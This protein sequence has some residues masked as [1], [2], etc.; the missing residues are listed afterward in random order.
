M[1]TTEAINR[2]NQG[3]KVHDNKVCFALCL[4]FL[5]FF[6]FFF[7][8]NLNS[9]THQLLNINWNVF[10]TANVAL[11]FLVTLHAP[12]PPQKTPKIVIQEVYTDILIIFVCFKDI[13]LKSTF[14]SSLEYSIVSHCR[15]PNSR[16]RK[17]CHSSSNRSFVA[18]WKERSWRA[19]EG[20]TRA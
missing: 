15:E 12:Y 14:L 10:T 1:L 11:G 8:I 6:P 13:E 4:S 19:C 5:F 2:V 3:Q 17:L 16:C 18:K 20:Q 7:P 9:H